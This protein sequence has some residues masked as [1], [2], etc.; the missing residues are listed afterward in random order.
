VLNIGGPGLLESIY[1]ECLCHGLNHAGIGYVRQQRLPDK[2]KGHDIDCNFQLDLI[3]AQRLV[4][5][6]K[7]AANRCRCM[8]RSF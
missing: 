6:I 7:A 1:E 8:R 5:E 2:Y 4:L 3:V